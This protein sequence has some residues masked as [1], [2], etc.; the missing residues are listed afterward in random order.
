MNTRISLSTLSLAGTLAATCL[1]LA[2]AFFQDME[3]S[4]R[5]PRP[6]APRYS[7]ERVEMRRTTPALPEDWPPKDTAPRPLRPPPKGRTEVR[8]PAIPRIFTLNLTTYISGERVRVRADAGGDEGGVLRPSMAMD[9]VPAPPASAARRS[10]RNA[11]PSAAAPA[12]GTGRG[13]RG[14]SGR[15]GARGRGARGEVEAGR[16]R[17]RGAESE[18]EAEAEE[19]EE[20]ASDIFSD[21]EAFQEWLRVLLLSCI[22][23]TPCPLSP[24][25]PAT[26]HGIAAPPSSGHPRPFLALPCPLTPSQVLP[27][28]HVRAPPLRAHGRFVWTTHDF[29]AVFAEKDEGGC[30]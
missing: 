20:A 30:V 21:V 11:A 27:P 3:A 12:R 9:S 26:H 18:D 29:P 17:K 28:A 1:L 13:E 23:P 6:D 10:A 19:G 8:L 5:D 25:F 14:G 2:F 7:A 4:A 15:G 24:P 22:P 16:K